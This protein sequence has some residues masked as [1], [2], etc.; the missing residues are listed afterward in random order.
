MEKYWVFNLQN[1]WNKSYYIVSA[2]QCDKLEKLVFVVFYELI[3][4]KIVFMLKLHGKM[5][6]L[7]EF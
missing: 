3:E 6:I 1:P 2:S 7:H 4:L 5:Q